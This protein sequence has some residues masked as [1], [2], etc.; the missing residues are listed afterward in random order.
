MTITDRGTMRPVSS[1]WE[2]LEKSSLDDGW[3]EKYFSL[4]DSVNRVLD[5]LTKNYDIERSS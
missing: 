2:D 1:F 3:R 4:L 5:S